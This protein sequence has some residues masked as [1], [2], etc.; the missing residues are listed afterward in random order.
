MT[1]DHIER[2]TVTIIVVVTIQYAPDLEDG[3]FHVTFIEII[4][5]V[6]LSSSATFACMYFKFTQQIWLKSYEQCER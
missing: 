6:D 4:K 3:H 2:K 5:E 1:N